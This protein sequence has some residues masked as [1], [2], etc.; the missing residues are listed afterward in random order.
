[1][2]SYALIALRCLVNNCGFDKISDFGEPIVA[3]LLVLL[4]VHCLQFSLS[5]S[6]LHTMCFY[7]QSL[8]TVHNPFDCFYIF[9]HRIG[10]VSTIIFLLF[11]MFYVLIIS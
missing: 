11:L 2:Q 3:S 1:M 10:V 4:K 6:H 9:T 8:H 7:M 5:T